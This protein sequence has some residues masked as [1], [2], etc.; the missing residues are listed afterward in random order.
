L[1]SFLDR[2][3]LCGESPAQPEMAEVGKLQPGGEVDTRTHQQGN[4]DRPPNQCSCLRPELAHTIDRV[5]FR[6]VLPDTHRR[7]KSVA[8]DLIRL[9]IMGVEGESKAE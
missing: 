9:T 8:I 5:P 7:T 3:P 6:M 4:R 1:I 2:S